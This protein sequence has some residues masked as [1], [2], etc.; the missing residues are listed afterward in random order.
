M[1]KLFLSI[2]VPAFGSFISV[3]GT[4]AAVWAGDA[5][6]ISLSAD[7]PPLQLLRSVPRAPARRHDR[8]KPAA[9][10]AKDVR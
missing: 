3:S 10:S 8:V 9:A 7:K 5:S 6:S 4:H 2:G 1:S